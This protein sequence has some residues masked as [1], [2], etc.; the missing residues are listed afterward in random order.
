VAELV[1][2]GWLR[3][4]FPDL[5]NLVV[6]LNESNRKVRDRWPLAFDLEGVPRET[7]ERERLLKEHQALESIAIQEEPPMQ[8]THPVPNSFAV[9]FQAGNNVVDI[10]NPPKQRYVHQEFPKHVYDHETGR[11]LEVKDER[12]QKAALKKG[13]KLE[14]ALDRDYSKIT[15]S[16]NVAP[17][18]PPAPEP[19]LSD[20]EILAADEEG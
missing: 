4:V 16:G 15:R 3:P 5:R 9:D 19:I 18:K 20:A 2:A 1:E 10:N 11:V 7:A 17:T 8:G 14:P 12:E 6:P 13:F